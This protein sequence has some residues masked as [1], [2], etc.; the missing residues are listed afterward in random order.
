VGEDD[1]VTPPALAEEFAARVGARAQV[2]RVAHRSHDCCWTAD[3]AERISA[4]RSHS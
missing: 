4:L 3:W 1:A 2:E